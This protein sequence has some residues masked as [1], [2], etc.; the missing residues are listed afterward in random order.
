[1]FMRYTGAMASVSQNALK[2]SYCTTCKG[3]LHHL[4]QTL[5]AN[6]KAEEGNPNVEFVVL[7]YG[8]EDGL[9]QWIKENFSAEIASGRLRY[10]RYEPAPHF[11]TSHAK[12]M[13]HR[14]STGDILCNVDADNFI[15]PNFS[16]WL[17]KAHSGHAHALSCLLP[18][19]V[20][21]LQERRENELKGVKPPGFGGGAGRV[22]INRKTFE[23]LGGYDESYEGWGF[24]DMDLMLRAKT[25]NVPINKIPADMVG[26]VIRHDHETRFA[27]FSPEGIKKSK[28]RLGRNR[29][30]V[31]KENYAAYLETREPV[32]NDGNVGCGKVVVN[33]SD[34]PYF[35]GKF[36]EP[37]SAATRSKATSWAQRV[38]ETSHASKQLA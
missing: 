17:I 30:Q 32:V 5:P 14:L 16:R 33:F 10:A 31:F 19:T 13:A 11:K 2:V 12:N 24:E 36:E 23:K 15:A 37:I 8:S 38:S 27:N 21:D 26:R 28:S 6:L 4:K 7:D 34:Q 9:G 29:A 22:A 25:A 35:I 1:M 18:I 3:R 20:E